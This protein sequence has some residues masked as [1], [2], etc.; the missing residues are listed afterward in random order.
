[1]KEITDRIG[2]HKV[3]LTFL[4][5][6]GWLE[7]EQPISDYGIDMHVEILDNGQPTGQLIALQI[8]SGESYFKEINQTEIVF[9]GKKKHLDYWQ[10]HSIPVLI[11]L[12]HPKEDKIYWEKILAKNTIAT[13]GGWKINISRKNIL[14]LESKEEI[15]KY[16][17]NRNH[18]TTLELS[19]RSHGAARRVSASI[20]VENNATSKHSMKRMIP[21]LVEGFKR[22]DY[23][24]NEITRN[25]FHNQEADIVFLFFYKNILQVKRGLPF[26]SV[27]W[28]SKKCTSKVNI[29]NPDEIIEEIE[30]KWETQN[31]QLE[32]IIYEDSMSKGDYLK[33]ASEAY[34]IFTKAH[35]SIQSQFNK[36][37]KN[38]HFSEL[39]LKILEFE[40]ELKEM[41]T[42]VN[43][44]ENF[45][46]LECHDIDRLITASAIHLNDIILSLKDESR[47]ESNIISMVRISL[48][49]T[50]ENLK[51]FDYE[52]RKIQ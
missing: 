29:P 50:E 30:I 43:F 40:K 3:A 27:I 39:K 26:C 4:Q 34:E 15:E 44:K 8:K 10:F 11:L 28:N 20:L 49:Q 13:G 12:Y 42:K 9:R 19:D 14:S 52:L 5:Q 24:R 21:Y 37:L 2:V 33:L 36:Y 38:P 47:P 45:T 6:M 32:D 23:Y 41:D 18:F 25:R 22:S 51:Y 48:Q 16:Y 35:T 46:P 31:N 7:R 17:Y 1:M